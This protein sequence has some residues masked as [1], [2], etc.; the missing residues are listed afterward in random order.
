MTTPERPTDPEARPIWGANAPGEEP[1]IE[2]VPTPLAPRLPSTVRVK[3]G[4][5]TSRVANLLLGLAVVV[6]IGGIAFAAGRFTAPVA[7]AG[8]NGG[9]GRQF[10]G[11]GGLQ[12]GFGNGNGG[13]GGFP[14]GGF[15]RGSAVLDGTI[16]AVTADSL[17]LRLGDGANGQGIEI[18]IPL[19][20]STAVHTQANASIDDLVTGQT[21]LVQLGTATS[22]ASPAPVASGEPRGVQAPATDVTIVKH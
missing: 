18:K 12:G 11:N 14:G 17:T 2:P 6:A 8:S 5:S 9:T 15:L 20:S 22:A 7:A 4:T 21:V 13:A 19:T 16:V 10:T 3:A 1:R